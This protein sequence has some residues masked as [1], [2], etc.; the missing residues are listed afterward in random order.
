MNAAHEES[1]GF[2]S[3]TLRRVSAPSDGNL[4]RL[5]EIDFHPLSS[6]RGLISKVFHSTEVGRHPIPCPLLNQLTTFLASL[7]SEERLARDILNLWTKHVL[8]LLVGQ[9]IGPVHE[10]LDQKSSIDEHTECWQN[11]NNAGSIL[12]GRSE[13]CSRA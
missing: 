7:T 9:S 12:Y 5:E 8:L 4:F 13:R 11:N 6:C 2:V 1:S 10:D 3:Q